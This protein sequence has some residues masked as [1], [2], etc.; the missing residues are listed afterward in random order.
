M[1][2]SCSKDI[3]K[4]VRRYVQQ[5]WMFRRGKKHGILRPPG[6]GGLFV[7]VPGT[8][9]DCRALNNFERD[10]TRVL[11]LAGSSG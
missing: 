6:R 1:R 5:D 10:L 8:P 3:D 11:R 7:V 2:Y 9:S 4:L